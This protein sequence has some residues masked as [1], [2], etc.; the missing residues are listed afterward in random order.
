MPTTV[1]SGRRSGYC[2]RRTTV[3]DGR[4]VSVV[5]RLRSATRETSGWAPAFAPS[6]AQRSRGA[7]FVDGADCC[8]LLAD[9]YPR[10]YDDGPTVPDNG[11]A[12][13]AALLG[14]A[15]E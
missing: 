13:R 11:P 7:V 8:W 15:V 4:N 2:R 3:T 5:S 14:R 9:R 6:V 1:R 12:V 10:S